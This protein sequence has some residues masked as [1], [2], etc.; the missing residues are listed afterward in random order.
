MKTQTL[1]SSFRSLGLLIT[2]SLFLTSCGSFTQA[3]FYAQDGIYSNSNGAVRNV[4]TT[5]K[6]VQVVNDNPNEFGSYFSDRANT[7]TLY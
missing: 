3:S 5:E 4:A 2:V 7:Y 1:T 6:A